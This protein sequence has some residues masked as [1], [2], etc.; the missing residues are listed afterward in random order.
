MLDHRATARA[1][2]ANTTG[3]PAFGALAMLKLALL[4]ALL[5][6]AAALAAEPAER[7]AA[8]C[9]GCHGAAGGMPAFAGIHTADELATMLREFRANARPATVMGRIARGYTDDEITTLAG[10]YARR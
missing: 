4:A 6:P 9:Q 10:F 5:L 8:P 1:V 2:R 3:D 7:L